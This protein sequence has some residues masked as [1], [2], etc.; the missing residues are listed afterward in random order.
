[1]PLHRRRPATARLALAR[2][3]TLALGLAMGLLLG[4]IPTRTAHTAPAWQTFASPEDRPRADTGAARLVFLRPAQRQDAGVPAEVF[5][6][7]RL[8]TALLPGGF[9]EIE[10]CPGGIT[11]DI[12]RPLGADPRPGPATRVEAAERQTR[13]LLVPA[14]E[15]PGAAVRTIG[16]AQAQALLPELRRQTHVLS[17]VMP[18]GPC[19][20][21]AEPAPVPAA[22][23]VASPLPAQQAA[24]PPP[25]PRAPQ[26]Y[27][28][29]AETLFTFNGSRPQHLSEQGQA[30]I[31]RLARRLK[32]DLQ[33]SQQV[34]VQGHSD[35]MGQPALNQRLS[36]ER[37][38]TVR[39][40]LINS[41]LPARQVRAE[42]LGSS[43][44]LVKNC[45]RLAT[46]RDEQ[47]GCNR[48][49]RRVEITVTPP[50]P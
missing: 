29:S 41:G 5:V 14:P 8:H 1:M 19:P 33:P 35:P 7:G 20:V 39:Q 45:A 17:R 32:D 38:E 36:L 28:L 25:S 9:S 3:S 24:A 46:Q 26:R 27:T 13:Y 2:L 31:V 43:Q 48:P 30:Q 42:G 22:L 15:A 16:A 11:V 18:S 44:P 40:I 34:L 4:L 21:H 10:V 12:A 23:H 50:K 49:N 6:D 47:L 37:A